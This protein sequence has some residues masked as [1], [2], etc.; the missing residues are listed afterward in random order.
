[1][2]RTIEPGQWEEIKLLVPTKVGGELVR[3][4]TVMTNDAR[5]RVVTLMAH[6]F[7][8]VAFRAD[9]PLINFGSVEPAPEGHTQKL[10]LTRGDGGPLSPRVVPPANPRISA[11]LVEITPGEKYELTAKLSPPWTMSYVS[12]QL[13]LQTG[14]AEMPT[15]TLPLVAQVQPRLRAL[16]ERLVL[17][18][19]RDSQ[20]AVKARLSWAGGP[21]GRVLGATVSDPELSVEVREEGDGSWVVLTIPPGFQPK[22]LA[23]LSV[24]VRTDDELASTLTIPISLAPAHRPPPARPPI[25]P[26]RTPPPPAATQPATTAP[27]A[28]PAATAPPATK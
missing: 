6:G 8:K 24:T 18:P 11:E 2:D 28:V 22:N 27:A 4:A 20:A 17:P 26:P 12:E 16:P 10:I 15:A 19:A 21:P 25:V 5:Q 13:V 9:P 14:V 3:Q 23:E 1:M 7:V